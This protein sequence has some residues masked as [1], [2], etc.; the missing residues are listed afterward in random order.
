MRLRQPLASPSCLFSLNKL[1]SPDL[2]Q[3]ANY[4]MKESYQPS[5]TIAEIGRFLRSVVAQLFVCTKPT[6]KVQPAAAGQQRSA[7]HH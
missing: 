4:I 1:R 7:P 5:P 2:R 3:F 6:L